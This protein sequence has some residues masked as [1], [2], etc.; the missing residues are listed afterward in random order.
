M[1]NRITKINIVDGSVLRHIQFECFGY[2]FGIYKVKQGNI[3]YG[4]MQITMLDDP[5]I[6]IN[7][8]TNDIIGGI[9]QDS[10]VIVVVYKN[11]LESYNPDYESFFIVRKT[12]LSLMIS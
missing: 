8:K 7:D 9:C 3:I 4:E 6:V 1:S 10:G 5:Q 11:E 12:E 2:N